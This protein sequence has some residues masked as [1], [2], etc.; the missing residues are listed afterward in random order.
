MPFLKLYN[1]I[2]C[3]LFCGP[4]IAAGGSSE[5]WAPQLKN[6]CSRVSNNECQCS[7]HAVALHPGGGVDRIAKETIARHLQAHHA[8]HHH[9]WVDTCRVCAKRRVLQHEV[10]ARRRSDVPTTRTDVSGGCTHPLGSGCCPPWTGPSGGLWSSTCPGPCR[11]C[12]AR[13]MWSC[14]ARPPRPCKHRVWSPPEPTSVETRLESHGVCARATS[15]RLKDWFDGLTVR[16]RGPPPCRRCASHWA[17]QR[18]CRSHWA[19]PPPAWE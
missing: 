12:D 6:P 2:Y 11:K 14:W 9:S 16:L 7:H 10:S 4:Q 17:C 1:I 18:R 13:G 19:C 15:D 5:V 8:G 3:K